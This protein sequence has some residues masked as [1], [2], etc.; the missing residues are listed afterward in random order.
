MAV[1]TMRKGGATVAAAAVVTE[2]AAAAPFHTAAYPECAL[3]HHRPNA[4]EEIGQCHFAKL[5]LR[6]P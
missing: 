4:A 6:E 2:A 3:S 5:G 1:A